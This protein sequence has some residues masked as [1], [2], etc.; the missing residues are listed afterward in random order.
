MIAA[1]RATLLVRVSPTTKIKGLRWPVSFSIPCMSSDYGAAFTS[2]MG[3]GAILR[4]LLFFASSIHIQ[5]SIYDCIAPAFVVFFRYPQVRES[6]CF[7]PAQ[8]PGVMIFKGLG[9]ACYN[10]G[11]IS[12]QFFLNCIISSIRICGYIIPYFHLIQS[13]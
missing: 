7:Q 5:I 4:F 2:L 1:I 8:Y 13:A 10:F 11:I 6:P 3:H 12:F 9:G